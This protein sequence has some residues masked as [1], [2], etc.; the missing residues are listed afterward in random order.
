MN[1]DPQALVAAAP[2]RAGITKDAEYNGIKLGEQV[3][4]HGD[5][6]TCIGFDTRDN[7]VRF[8]NERTG[9]FDGYIECYTWKKHRGDVLHKRRKPPHVETRKTGGMRD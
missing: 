4:R 7:V 2:S 6:I 5:T 8:F 1:Y 9:G 3:S